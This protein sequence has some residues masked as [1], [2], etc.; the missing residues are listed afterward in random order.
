MK[1]TGKRIGA[2]ALAALLSTAVIAGNVVPA[3]AASSSV[4]IVTLASST[5]SKPATPTNVKLTVS[6]PSK[7]KATVKLS[8]NK[9]SGATGYQVMTGGNSSM[10]MDD[11]TYTATGTSKSISYSR[12]SS[13]YKRYFKVRAYKT[14][15]GKRTYG[16][17]SAV[18]SVTIAKKS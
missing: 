15:N 7:T 9:V 8:W 6:Y 10:T 13:A 12:S 18:K 2:L 17:W 4:K 3:S 5:I 1:T 11:I 14:V 16:S